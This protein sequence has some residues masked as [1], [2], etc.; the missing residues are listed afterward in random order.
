MVA[1]VSRGREPNGIH[2]QFVVPPSGGV[3]Q[4]SPCIF[5]LKAGLQ[6]MAG[7]KVT[8]IGLAPVA[9]LCRPVGTASQ[10]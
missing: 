1:G 4:V 8:A 2:F 5:R 6:T 9:I 7:D 10:A 3:L